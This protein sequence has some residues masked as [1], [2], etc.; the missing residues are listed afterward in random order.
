MMNKRSFVLQAMRHRLLVLHAKPVQMP[1]GHVAS[2]EDRQSLRKGLLNGKRPKNRSSDTQRLRLSEIRR[3][4]EG[5]YQTLLMHSYSVLDIL[6]WMQEQNF[7]L[8]LRVCSLLEYCQE[9]SFESSSGRKSLTL[10][11]FSHREGSPVLVIHH[12][13]TLNCCKR[14]Q[15]YLPQNRSTHD[16]VWQKGFQL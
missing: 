14:F 11:V 16:K 13:V 3:M 12:T 15:F 6:F 8:S 2:G 7:N 9:S 1:K 4:S 5:R 10:S